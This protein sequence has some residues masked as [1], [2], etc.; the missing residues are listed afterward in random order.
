[1]KT[2]T[3]QQ[4]ALT[5]WFDGDCAL[6]RRIAK[7]L[8]AQPKFVPVRCVTAQSAGG[9]AACPLDT[10]ALLDK[11]TVMASDG[12][13]YRDSNAWLVVLWALRGYRAWSLRLSRERWR[14]W[15]NDL[16]GAIAGVGRLSKRKRR[17]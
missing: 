8:D 6:C 14:P 2:P 12:A 4:V 3:Q 9:T 13:V 11:L 10:D 1:M 17:R 5:V 7:W 16:F 15:A